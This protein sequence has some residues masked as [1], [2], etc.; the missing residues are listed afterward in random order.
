MTSKVTDPVSG[1]LKTALSVAKGGRTRPRLCRPH[2]IEVRY[3][4]NTLLL[5]D[6]V[7]VLFDDNEAV[8]FFTKGHGREE[9]VRVLQEREDLRSSLI[10]MEL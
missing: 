2:C 3:R 8:A 5:F 1:H 9:V 6:Y 7:A 4:K 10:A